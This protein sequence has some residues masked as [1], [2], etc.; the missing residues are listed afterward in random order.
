MWANLVEIPDSKGEFD[1]SSTTRS[2]Q[3]II[4]EVDSSSEEEDS[5][6]L[7]SRKGLKDLMAG[8][9]K[10]SSPKEA[11]KSPLPPLPPTTT[12]G[13]LPNPNLQKKRKEQVLEEGEVAHQKEAKQQK[14]AK[15]KWASFMDSKEEEVRQQQCTWAPRL[16]LNDTPIP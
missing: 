5:M 2:P 9:N 13:L 10:G 12:V 1:R 4:V 16:K 15:D 3:L 7:N 8:R 6:A 11:L 14:T